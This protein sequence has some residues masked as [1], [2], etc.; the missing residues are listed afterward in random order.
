MATAIRNLALVHLERRPEEAARVLEHC[1]REE[2]AALLRHAPP[3]VVAR[4][5]SLFTSRFAADCLVQLSPET[6]PGVVGELS[7]PTAAALLRHCPSAIREE[8]LDTLAPP[9]ATPIRDALGYPQNSAGASA[10]SDVL[11]LFE[12]QTVER[13]IDFL[14]AHEQIVPEQVLVLDRSRRVRGALRT[15]SLC[16]APRGAAVGSLELRAVPTIAARTPLAT[17]AD[18]RRLDG[19]PTP[20]VDR[21][22]ALVGVLD[23]ETLRRVAGLDRARPVTELVAAFSEL[24]WLGLAGVVSGM[25]VGAGPA[26]IERRLG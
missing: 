18:D 9:V 15:V 23:P 6:W 11:T 21:A 5:L 12:D 14:G 17:L 7:P 13:A 24:C 16:W 20:V 2:A 26:D 3:E 22:G 8:C 4:V 25:A 1:S 10:S 19:T